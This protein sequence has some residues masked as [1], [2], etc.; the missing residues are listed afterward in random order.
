M[1]NRTHTR[2]S[3]P[4]YTYWTKLPPNRES[5]GKRNDKLLAVFT[6]TFNRVF[7]LRYFEFEI[8]TAGP[9]RVGWARAECNP[10][11]MLGS[12][13]L[14][15][16]F[17]G[18]NVSHNTRKATQSK[19]STEREV[20]WPEKDLRRDFPSVNLKFCLKEEK[21]YMG[22]AESFGRQWQ[23]GDVVGVFL[24]L[25]DRTISKLDRVSCLASMILNKALLI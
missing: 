23:V 3:Q 18:Y 16:A 6:L 8:L 14:S 12:D 22:M 11:C 25:I 5:N 24:D 2:R 10:G 19:R 20:T 9:M 1:S 13:D 17:D 7:S 4:Y 15:W 21:V